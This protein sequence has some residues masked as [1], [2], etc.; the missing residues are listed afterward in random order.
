M[1]DQNRATGERVAR[2]AVT[3]FRHVHYRIAQERIKTLDRTARSLSHAIEQTAAKLLPPGTQVDPGSR[4]HRVAEELLAVTGGLQQ[5]AEELGRPFLLFVVGMGKFGKST[6]I[7]ALL[8][9]KVA[10]MDALPKTWKIDVFTSTLPPTAAEVRTYD[11]TVQTLTVDEAVQL[12]AD[13]ETRRAE[14]ERTVQKRFRE[15]SASL[16]TVAEKEVLRQELE[17][18]HLYRSP[19]V[20]VRWPVAAEGLARVFD[21]VDTPGLWQERNRRAHAAQKDR[22]ASAQAGNGTTTNQP[23]RETWSGVRSEDLRSYYLQADG[24]LWMLDA[25][26]LAAGKPHELIRTMDEA[27]ER[28]GGVSANSVGVLNRIDLVRQNGGEAAVARVVEEA[29]RLFGSIF[30][31][32][33]PVSAREALLAHE[34]GDPRRLQASGLPELLAVIDREFRLNGA[35]VRWRSKSESVRAY[36][37]HAASVGRAYET[38]LSSAVAE[39]NQRAMRAKRHLDTV[40]RRA[41]KAFRSALEEYMIHVQERV[42]E[43]ARALLDMPEEQRKAFIEQEILERDRLRNLVA[44][45]FRKASKQVEQRMKKLERSQLFTPFRYVMPDVTDVDAGLATDD[46]GTAVREDGDDGGAAFV[47]DSVLTVATS[48]LFYFLVGPWGILIGPLVRPVFK[49]MIDW[50]WTESVT[51]KLTNRLNVMAKQAEELF[52]RAVDNKV[53]QAEDRLR[54]VRETSFGRMH[55]PMDTLESV[56]DALASLIELDS[57]ELRPPG[58]RDITLTPLLLARVSGGRAATERRSA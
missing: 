7:N 54:I 29:R 50:I 26:K 25:T 33:V 39:L 16:A 56:K 42:H 19:I 22:I 35:T 8:G 13:E 43:K 37:A 52:N 4:S 17:E 5:L 27:M 28:I 20:E 49:W 40:K 47:V 15:M 46:I 48:A 3:V 10:A 57:L 58:V 32:I 31:H 30:Q 23:P 2:Q 12:I 11:G 55:V 1:A 51:S 36:A 18:I 14:S 41:T 24:V 21:V 38:E 45:H 53:H 34:A 44:E 6:L 9:Q